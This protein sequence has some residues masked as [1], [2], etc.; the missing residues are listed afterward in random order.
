[1]ICIYHG[2]DLDGWCSAAIVNRKFPDCK[3]TPYDYGQPIPDLGDDDEIIMVDVSFKPEIYKKLLAEGRRLTWLDHHI[4][5]IRDFDKELRYE[6][7]GNPNF[8][9]SLDPTK[10][11]CE[12]TWE[13]INPGQTMPE[14]VRKLGR[15][16][17]FGH[18]GTNEELDILKFQYAAR[19]RW[20][21]WQST[22]AVLT[23]SD[24]DL[25][26]MMMNGDA[27]YQYLC[28]EARQAYARGFTMDIDGYK[29]LAVNKDR[30]NPINFG[31][32]YHKDGYNGFC[33]FYYADGLWKFSLYN[34]DQKVDCSEI[35]KRRDGGGHAGAAGF[36]AKQIDQLWPKLIITK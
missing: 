5:A 3:M 8:K 11:A 22:S 33:S 14:G 32:D 29:F 28:T 34:D 9:F 20:N 23:L 4:S 13:Y 1:M 35:C 10:A 12:I 17:C 31:I 36:V 18:K 15:Y 6:V 19:A 2:I 27:I 30:F 26:I 25:I 7:Q 16:D 21:S 24:D